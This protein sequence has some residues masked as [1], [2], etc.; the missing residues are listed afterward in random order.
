MAKD[1]VVAEVLTSFN[2]A[3]LAG[4]FQA[5]NTDG[6]YGP[7]FKIRI[8]NASDVDVLISY[9]G[10]N[11]NDI[12]LADSDLILDFQDNSQLPNHRC[13]MPKGKI[14]YVAGAGAGTGLIYV[15]GY[16]Q[17]R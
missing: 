4:A 2:T 14:V 13:L 15:T 9:D 12:V 1:F 17:E 11:A 3:G 6:F 16:Y 7:P 10:V 8:V 5:V